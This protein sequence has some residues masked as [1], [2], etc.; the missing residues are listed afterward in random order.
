[1]PTSLTTPSRRRWALLTAL[2]AVLGVS[3]CEDPFEL[4]ANQANIDVTFE[5]WGLTGTPVAYPSAISVPFAV[6]TPLDA[7]GSFDL[8]FDV[9][10]DG[11]LLVYPVGS[12]VSPVGGIRSIGFQR[13]DLLYNQIIE[14]P[15]NGWATDSVFIVNPGQSFLVRVASAVCQGSALQDVYARFYVDSVIVPERRIKLS[16]RINPNCGFRALVSGIP[17]Y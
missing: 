14:A 6:A 4:R 5:L 7:A 11:R 9:D 10:P 8:A 2:A 15:R 1:V 17:P 12:I 16:S 3:A 13:T